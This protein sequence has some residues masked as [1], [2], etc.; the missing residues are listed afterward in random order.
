MRLA[1]LVQFTVIADP[2]CGIR[3]LPRFLFWS[4]S[5][6]PISR[7]SSA[8]GNF[9]LVPRPLSSKLTGR[10]P[11]QSAQHRLEHACTLGARTGCREPGVRTVY[12]ARYLADDRGAGYISQIPALGSLE[13]NAA[14]LWAPGRKRPRLFL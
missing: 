8:T 5:E 13:I 2:Q 14:S 3:A 12:A 4:V 10:G 7:L 6:C 1:F 11:Q 9:P